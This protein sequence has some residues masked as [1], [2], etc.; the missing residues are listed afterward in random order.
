MPTE[1]KQSRE[2]YQIVH[3]EYW[4]R[5]EFVRRLIRHRVKVNWELRWA[6]LASQK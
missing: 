2:S 6:M 1:E 4:R 3:D 5:V